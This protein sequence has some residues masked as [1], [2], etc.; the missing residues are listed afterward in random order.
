VNFQKFRAG[1]SLVNSGNSAPVVI[2]GTTK[3]LTLPGSATG[4]GVWLSCL[5]L[6]IG[7]TLWPATWSMPGA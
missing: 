7:L 3:P 1:Y 6:P 4:R 5:Y 2:S